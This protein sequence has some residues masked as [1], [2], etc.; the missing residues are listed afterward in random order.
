MYTIVSPWIPV[1]GCSRTE[2]RSFSTCTVLNKKKKKNSNMFHIGFFFDFSRPLVSITHNTINHTFAFVISSIFNIDVGVRNSIP[3]LNLIFLLLQN[4]LRF[5]FFYWSFGILRYGLPLW[6]VCILIQYTKWLVETSW[7]F[8]FNS[9][10]C[11][12][13]KGEV[14]KWDEKLKKL[15][16]SSWH[17]DRRLNRIRQ[18]EF[19]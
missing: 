8:V 6:Y 2:C 14:E 9:N 1:N 10:W 16:K 4:A 18:L 15:S 13:L 11:R 19:S 12:L 5:F 3:I 7:N 17:F